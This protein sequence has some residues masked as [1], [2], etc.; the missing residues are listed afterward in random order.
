M[1]RRARRV[2]RIPEE[3]LQEAATEFLAS[4]LKAIE[5][6]IPN[7]RELAERLNWPETSLSS[8]L[9]GRFTFKTWP[10]ICR[11]LGRDP[12]DE[13]VRGR[14]LLREEREAA[15]AEQQAARDVTYREM[16]ERA[17]ADTMVALWR[18]LPPAERARVA[19]EL[20]AERGGK[21]C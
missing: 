12:I 6:K 11:A 4:A 5:G 18:M 7:Q 17:Q 16:L 15:R 9:Q 3:S 21:L 14:E 10:R 1:P 19:E 20:T 2:R 8:A 13:L